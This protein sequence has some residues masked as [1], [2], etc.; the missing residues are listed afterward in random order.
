MFIDDFSLYMKDFPKYFGHFFLK[1]LLPLIVSLLFAYFFG[2][3]ILRR[4]RENDALRKKKYKFLLPMVGVFITLLGALLLIAYGFIALKNDPTNTEIGIGIVLSLTS[5][6]P[7]GGL[8]FTVALAIIGFFFDRAIRTNDFSFPTKGVIKM[9]LVLILLITA[10][11]FIFNK[12]YYLHLSQSPTQDTS[13]LRKAMKDNNPDLCSRNRWCYAMYYQEIQDASVCAS[14]PNNMDFYDDIKAGNNIRDHCYIHYAKKDSNPN[15]CDFVQD[16]IDKMGCLN[17]FSTNNNNENQSSSKEKGVANDADQKQNVHEIGDLQEIECPAVFTM[18]FVLIEKPNALHTSQDLEYLELLQKKVAERFLWATREMASMDTS[19]PVTLLQFKETPKDTEATKDF[20]N[21]HGDLFDFVTFYTTYEADPRKLSSGG[22]YSMY[23]KKAQN[24]IEG[25]G[26]LVHDASSLYGSKGNLLG[27]NW[28]G[29]LRSDEQYDN[30]LELA[31]NGIL[32]ETSHQWGAKV[33]F[34]DENGQRSE[35]LRSGPHWKKTLNSGYSFLGG[36]SWKEN[37]DGSFTALQN[38]D[39]KKNYSDIDLYIMG[40]LPKEQ[41]EPLELII[42]TEKDIY[43][44]PGI[45]ISGKRKIIT[46]DQIISALGKRK[47]VIP[48]HR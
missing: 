42:P 2:R 37:T 14:M 1:R 15:L 45:T 10:G 36:F 33:D 31:V 22:K 24:Y 39:A 8:I 5:V 17:I 9:L 43:I 40:L 25:I 18:A 30:K 21:K 32:H 12:I 28:M 38:A 11:S 27:I 26:I 7:L 4:I 41:I 34:I 3:N 46:V 47:C 35:A 6:L 20:I 29:N 19:Y 23:H 16:K 13:I 44:S 48:E